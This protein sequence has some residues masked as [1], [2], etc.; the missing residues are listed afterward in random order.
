[1]KDK[2]YFCGKEIDTEHSSH[3]LRIVDGQR[4]VAHVYDCREMKGEDVKSNAG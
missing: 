4:V 1:M 3:A 2:C